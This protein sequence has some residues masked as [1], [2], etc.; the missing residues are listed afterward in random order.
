MAS[1]LQFGKDNS[2][3]GGKLDFGTD[4]QG[5]QVVFKADSNSIQVWLPAWLSV[6]HMAVSVK[7]TRCFCDPGP[8]EG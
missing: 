1:R 2:E 7:G 5:A 6:G 8:Q 4:T 3:K